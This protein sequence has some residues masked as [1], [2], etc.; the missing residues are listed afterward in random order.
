MIY[1]YIQKWTGARPIPTVALGVR[2]QLTLWYTVVFFVLILGSG[3]IVYKYLEYTLP[4]TLDSTLS[5]RAN[6]L[7]NEVSY[8]D[9]TIRIQDNSGNFPGTDLSKNGLA[10]KSTDVD[11]SAV[12]RLLD[13]HEH[14]IR[15]TATFR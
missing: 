5:L 10:D 14:I 4:Q 9:G 12:I 11:G 1:S 3:W 13:T 8:I 7:A 2:L 15:A 6:Q